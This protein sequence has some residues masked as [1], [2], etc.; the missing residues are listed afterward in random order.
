[1]GLGRSLYNIKVSDLIS[2]NISM[3]KFREIW[4]TLGLQ[5]TRQQGHTVE[6]IWDAM[7]NLRAMYPNAGSWE[8]VNLLFHEHNMSVAQ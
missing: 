3:T 7:I 6:T 4:K 5:R 2:Y 8:M 1:M